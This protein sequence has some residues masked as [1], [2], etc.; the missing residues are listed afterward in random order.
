V[1]RNTLNIIPVS[2]QKMTLNFR[3]PDKPIK[4]VEQREAEL[5][6]IEQSE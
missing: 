4:Q 2:E 5:E 3:T 1:D 6:I